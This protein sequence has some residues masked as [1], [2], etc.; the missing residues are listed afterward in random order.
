[1]G[2]SA[3]RRA[4]TAMITKLVSHPKLPRPRNEAE[5]EVE[6]GATSAAYTGDAG[7]VRLNEIR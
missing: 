2:V 1:M 6:K 7:T 4:W 5:Q 3:G